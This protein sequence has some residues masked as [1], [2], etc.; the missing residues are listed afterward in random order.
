MRRI[1]DRALISAAVAAASILAMPLALGQAPAKKPA[2]ITTIQHWIFLIKENRTFDNYFANFPGA[3]SVTSGTI[4]TGQVITLGHTPDTPPLDPTHTWAAAQTAIDYGR[5][6]DFD[7]ACGAALMG[8]CMTQMYQQDVPNYWNYASAFTLSDNT[9]ASLHGVSFPN[10]LYMIGAQSDGS[11]D[12]PPM[13]VNSW[14]C[15]SP[16]GTVVPW[17]NS[18]GYVSNVFPCFDFNTLADSMQTAGL[19]WSYYAP[20]EGERG[21]AWS[22]F[23]AINHIRN[24]SLWTEHVFPTTQFITD[25]Q[26]GKLPA[27]AWLTPPGYQS[28]HPQGA[29]TCAGENWTVSMIN[30]VMQSPEWDSTAIV[31]T[32][33]DYGGF[34][35]HVAPPQLDFYGLGQRVPLLVISPYAKPG[36][37]TH[38]QY[39]FSSFLKTVEERFGLA[40]L[41]ERDANANDLLDSFDFNESPLPPLVLN[42]RTC[43]VV[44]PL[45]VSFPPQKVN[46]TSTPLVV[47]VGNWTTN[48]MTI[49]SIATTGDF[50]QTNACNTKLGSDLN[51]KISVNF[52]PKTTGTISGTLTVTD[53]GAGSPQ[54]VTLTGQGTEVSL[55]P[56]LVSFGSTLVGKSSQTVTAKLTNEASGKLNISNIAVSGDYSQT[57]NCGNSVAGKGSCT[58]NVTFTPTATGVRYGQITITDNGGASPQVIGLTGMGAETTLNPQRLVFGSV[59]IGQSSAPET[60]TIANKGTTTLTLGAIA[61]HDTTFHNSPD[62]SYVTT[63]GSS[64]APHTSCT[65]TVTFTPT[66][67]G[68]RDGVLLVADSDPATTPITV[69]MSGT[70]TP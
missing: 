11:V 25:A 14:G 34:Y 61:V 1:F 54:V 47:E 62:Y 60:V 3:N 19:T 33:D 46:T 17:V 50:K 67:A 38:T 48:T 4:S 64:L 69:P 6:D 9:F 58:F 7:Q 70:G 30:A 22:S 21:Y 51:C 65:F 2:D 37:V 63:C 20:S 10:H 59:V 15:D 28:E 36:Y 53:S 66:A 24:T 39:E 32:W 8:V 12:N 41:T 45:E 35:D 68:N 16:V 43:P 57:N 56:G 23:D 55:A 18:Q 49:S 42:Q 26:A 27:L 31:V 40:P 29:S 5:M 13:A 52:T 44:S